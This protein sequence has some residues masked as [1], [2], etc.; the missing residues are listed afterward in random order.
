MKTV[1]IIGGGKFGLRAARVIS[2]NNPGTDMVLIDKNPQLKRTCE[3]MAIKFICSEAVSFLHEN[4]EKSNAPEW[5]V[6]AIPVHVAFEWIKRELTEMGYPVTVIDV[7]E[8]VER[9]LPNPVRGRNGAFYISNADFMCP[10]NCPEPETL[11]TFTG[12]PRPRILYQT[13]RDLRYRDFVSIV[14]QSHQ[15][16]PGAGGFTPGALFEALSRIK[17]R[18]SPVFISTSCSCHAVMHAFRI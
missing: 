16:A 8:E 13:L 5:I 17:Q 14:I 3:D 10:D 6:P 18:S 1:W 2:R 11:C 7:P 12:K 15:L 9:V 4:M